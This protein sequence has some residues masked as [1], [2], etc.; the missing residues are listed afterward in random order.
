MDSRI[1]E[2]WGQFLIQAAKNQQLLEQFLPGTSGS[3]GKSWDFPDWMHYFSANLPNMQSVFASS[4]GLE[5]L[6]D[7]SK[8][9][10][11]AYQEAWGQWYKQCEDCAQLLGLVPQGIYEKKVQ[12]NQELQQKIQ[13]QEQTIQKLRSLLEQKAGLD[14]EQTAKDMGQLF[15]EQNK[16]FSNL[17]QNL[18]QIWGKDSQAKG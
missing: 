11:Q 6:S 10:L 14:L 16:Q 9:L 3:Q 7:S 4:S 5:H 12:E 13:Q 17:L 8:H 2:L 15:Q 1:L 18:E